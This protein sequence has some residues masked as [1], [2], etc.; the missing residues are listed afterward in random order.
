MS[1]IFENVTQSI[2]KTPLIRLAHVVDH[3]KVYAKIEGRNPTTS[4]KDRIG[5]SMIEAG[6]KDGKIKPGAT[7]IEPTSGNTGIALAWVCAAKGYK[8][9]LTMP[10]TMTV[11]RR[12][13]LAAFGAELILTPGAEGMKGAISRAGE[14]AEKEGYFLPDQ[15]SNPAN[16]EIHFTTTGPELWEAT[17]GKMDILIS[18]IG[19]GGTITGV[20]EVLKEKNPA[21][22]SIALEPATSPVL[23]RWDPGPGNTIQGIGAGFVPEVLNTDIIDE[24]MTVVNE[25]AF[26]M[27]RDAARIEGLPCGISSGAA[28]WAA[29]QVAARD[30]MEGKTIVA[31]LPSFAE[32]YMS[33][34]LFD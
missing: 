5:V 8:L 26:A 28:I 10:D 24:V 6:E 1:E 7:I 12:R 25:D 17:D 32:R 18:G 27:A 20:S 4:V 13:M 30:G 22:Y 29:M 11:E 34:A 31:V 19:T 2:G 9:I 16:P 15:F 23:S 3:P 21:L 33:T 14:L